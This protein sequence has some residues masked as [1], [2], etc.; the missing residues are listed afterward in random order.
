M[1]KDDHVVTVSDLL[2]SMDEA[3]IDVSLIMA[4]DIAVPDDWHGVSADDIIAQRGENQRIKVI[5]NISIS[6]NINAQLLQLQKHIEDGVVV[7]I[8]LYPGY[9]NFYPADKRLHQVYEFC[10]RFHVPVVLHTG[11][12]LQGSSGIQ[13]QAHPSCIDEVATRFPYLT[14]VMAH[15]GNPWV[16]DAAKIMATYQNA[17]VDLSGFFVEYEPLSSKE[18]IDFQQKIEE[19]STVVGDLE[20]CIFG[21]DWP[22]YGQKEYLAVV[23]EL[24]MS[25]VER[26]LVFWKN[27]TTVFKLRNLDSS[28]NK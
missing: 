14:I 24:P 23:R 16:T 6:R 22:L 25:N 3:R 8:K 28:T 5:G 2:Q 12:L 10:H 19:L 11:F 15:F 18:K 27:A 4:N 1:G 21:T 20:K 26:E 17:Y 9:E 7:G 13:K